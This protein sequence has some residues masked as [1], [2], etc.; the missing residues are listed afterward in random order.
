MFVSD[1]LI[2]QHKKE[3][4]FKD[5][6]NHLKDYYF[7][8]E[9]RMY[10]T[11]RYVRL[12]EENGNAFSY[13]YCSILRDSASLFSSVLK[14]FVKNI[15]GEDEPNIKNFRDFLNE[16][17]DNIHLFYIRLADKSK[18][19]NLMPYIQ[20]FQDNSP[21][22]WI[23]HNDIKH[24]ETKHYMKGNLRNTINSIAALAILGYSLEIYQWRKPTLFGKMPPY[25]YNNKSQIELD[26]IL[27][28]DYNVKEEDDPFDKLLDE[29]Q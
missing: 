20:L 23:S 15:E 1:E 9:D 29:E 25:K 16:Y 14:P 4:W 8:I 26:F 13:E 17:W 19:N 27:F 5:T 3:D 2:N 18:S 11:F 7:S 28:R 12:H 6:R 21:N 10:E 24:N 22:W